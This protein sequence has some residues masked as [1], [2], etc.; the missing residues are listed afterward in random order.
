MQPAAGIPQDQRLLSLDALRGFVMLWIIGLDDAYNAAMKIIRA[1]DWL[2]QQSKHV[3]WAGFHCYDLILPMFVFVMGAAIPLAVF[4]HLEGGDSRRSVYRHTAR[5]VAILVLLGILYNGGMRLAGFHETRFASVLGFIGVTYGLATVVVLNC[6]V[7]AQAAF[8]AGILLVYGAAIALIPVPNLA[9]TAGL[10]GPEGALA[11]FVDQHFLPGRLY[12]GSHDPE[13]LLPM[14]SG[15]AIAL[16]GALAG[17]WL[18]RTDKDGNAKTAGLLAAGTACILA[19][20]AW[21]L[22]LPIVK[23]VWT[24]SFVV[25][26][27]GWCLLHLALFYWLMDVRGWRKLGFPLA[28]VGANAI[29][30]YLMSVMVDFT[31]PAQFL[32]SGLARLAGKPWDD[33]IVTCGI[34]A[35]EWLLLWFLWRKRVFLRV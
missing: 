25:Y 11:A 29:L 9:V 17:E 5:R 18:R 12:D 28:V 33:L 32:L 8:L 20:L 30:I 21:N 31:L 26:A 4:K 6:G 3:A 15:V 19:G 7:R 34:L 24:P 14:A 2:A 22:R 27:G 16:M 10:G 1:P 13:G 23:N 35:L